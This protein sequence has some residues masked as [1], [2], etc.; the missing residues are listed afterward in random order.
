MEEVGEYKAQNVRQSARIDENPHAL[1]LHPFPSCLCAHLLDVFPFYIHVYLI[2][3]E[4]V[5]KIKLATTS[6]GSRV[7]PKVRKKRGWGRKC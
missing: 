6:G 4:E 7:L 3:G 5:S 2:A 1:W